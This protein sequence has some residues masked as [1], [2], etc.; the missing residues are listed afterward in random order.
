MPMSKHKQR[1][2]DWKK[3]RWVLL[4]LVWVLASWLA[5]Q[6]VA[7]FVVNGVFGNLIVQSVLKLVVF[8][9]MS[10]V[11]WLL[12]VILVPWKVLKMKTNREELGL[13]GL[14]TWTDVGL[15]P[16]GFAVY[17]VGA[18]LVLALVT[19]IFPSV[20]WET[21][22]D[23]GIRFSELVR[24]SDKILVFAVMVILAPV[25]E[26]IIFRG[27]LYGKVRAKVPAWVGIVTVSVL[28]GSL[29][30]FTGKELQWSAAVGIFCL[31]VVLCTL[32]EITG[33]IWSGVIL[34]ML[35]NGLGFYMRLIDGRF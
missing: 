4:L 31:S 11:L 17:F 7:A 8:S 34:H 13:S 29:H 16:V 19:A 1:K 10:S 12:L 30:L 18:L 32:R 27:W 22:Q 25:V 21:S 15:A 23:F 5:S 24:V 9:V 35:V 14:P 2:F 20:D 28:F 26:E 33:T 6:Y 3:V